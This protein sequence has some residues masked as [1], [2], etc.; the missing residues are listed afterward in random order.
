AVLARRARVGLLERFE[1]DA[2]L[3]RRD[4]DAGVDDF[5]RDDGRRVIEDRMSR[6]PAALD[7]ARGELDAAALG[8]LERV[9]E[10]VLEDLLQTLRI[11]CQRAAE[12]RGEV[13]AEIET[14]AI[15]FVSEAALHVL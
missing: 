9:R 10:Q 4:A 1:H 13:D 15:G 12:L 8:E 7:R 11:G 6:R 5:E 3:V 14:T 2:L